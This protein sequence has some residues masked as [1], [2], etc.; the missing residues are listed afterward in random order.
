MYYRLQM[1]LTPLAERSKTPMPP[2][3]AAHS[4]AFTRSPE[5]PAMLAA[6]EA[7]LAAEGQSAAA[8]LNR[9]YATLRPCVAQD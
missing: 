3:A 5:L 9:P 2:P 6:V 8:V 7:L 4:P 1:N